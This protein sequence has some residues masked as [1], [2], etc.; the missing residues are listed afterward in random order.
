M[1]T[2]LLLLAA[3]ALSGPS[4]AQEDAPAGAAGAE[5]PTPDD[6]PPSGS[7]PDAPGSE[8]PGPVAPGRPRLVVLLSVDQL[9]P[10]QLERLGPDLA[11]GLGR[12]LREGRSLPGAAL[13]YARTETGAGRSAASTASA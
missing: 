7:G 1:T 5:A 3:L 4:Q 12:L 9:I 11:G 2:S 13:P 10:D 6:P 8:A